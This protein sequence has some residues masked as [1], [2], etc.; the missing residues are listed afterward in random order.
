MSILTQHF[1]TKHNTA[2]FSQIKIEDY[3]PAFNEAIALAKA[4][5]DAIVNNPDEPTFENKV[6][7]FRH[8]S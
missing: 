1:N 8:L 2:P 4:E 7:V 6:S 5:I 3:V